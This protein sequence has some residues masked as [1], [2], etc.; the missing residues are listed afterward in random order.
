MPASPPSKY[1][2]DR[3][4]KA[5]DYIESIPVGAVVH[6]RVGMARAMGVH[7]TTLQEWK[8]EADKP[9]ISLLL[10]EVV[11]M[12][13]DELL[14]NGLSGAY[15]STITKLMLT[16]HGYHDKSES[17]VKVR[18]AQ[19]EVEQILRENGIDPASV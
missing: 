10:Q 4:Q 2:E 19:T 14:N 1:T 18:M 12:Q 8:K 11:D 17:D 7:E 16:K 6:S 3:L 13:H 9:E 5:R 15:N